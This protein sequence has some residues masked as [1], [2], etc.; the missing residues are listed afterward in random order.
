MKTF[1]LSSLALLAA[2]AS[3]GALA[4]LTPPGTNTPRPPATLTLPPGLYVSVIDGLIK[5]SNKGGTSQFAAGQ[6]GFTPTP[7]QP[8]ILVPKNPGIPFTPPPAFTQSTPSG[9][10]ARPSTV[11]CEVR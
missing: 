11:N 4:Q 1:T 9:S 7:T 10:G 5:V 8:P 2:V 3:T 6:F